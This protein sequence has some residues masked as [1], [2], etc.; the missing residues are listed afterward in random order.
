[1]IELTSSR[2]MNFVQPQ[3]DYISRRIEYF[4]E[5]LK[6][7]IHF[8][9]YLSKMKNNILQQIQSFSDQ[10]QS[11]YPNIQTNPGSILEEI[12]STARNSNYEERKSNFLSAEEK[13]SIFLVEEFSPRNDFMKKIGKFVYKRRNLYT[14]RKTSANIEI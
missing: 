7:A 14:Y 2:Y 8:D 3:V 5:C 11:K 10:L 13:N 12:N 6:S 9:N 1:M 4:A